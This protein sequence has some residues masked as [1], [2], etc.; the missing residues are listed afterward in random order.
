MGLASRLKN[1]LYGACYGLSGILTGRTIVDSKQLDRGAR[2]IHAGFPFLLFRIGGWSYSD[3]VA[4]TH[5]NVRY[6][7]LCQ[8]QGL[9]EPCSGLVFGKGVV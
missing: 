1:G 7:L 2:M 4:S 5:G 3:C 6:L 9:N 8:P